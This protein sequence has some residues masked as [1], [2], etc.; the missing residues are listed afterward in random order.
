[1]ILQSAGRSLALLL[2]GAATIL[3]VSCTASHPPANQSSKTIRLAGDAWFLK[4]LVST[5]RIASFEQKTGVHVEVLEK[6]D[7]TILSDLDRGATATDPGY[8]L[9]VMRHRFMGTLVAKKQIQPIDSL[10]A[11]ASVHDI[12][13]YP[14]Q[15]LFPQ[16]WRELSWYGD[17]VYGY[18]Y[19]GLTAF[20]CYRKDMLED[21]DNQRKFKARYHRSL[22]VPAH[23]KEYM[24]VAEFFTR[25]G[26]HFYGTYISGKR[27][28]ALWYEWLNL[29]YSFG[30]DVLDTQHGW[31]YG[32]IVVNSPQ[33][34]AA[35]KQY[36]KW[37]AN[38]PPDT[39][40]YG[41]NEAQAAL[42]Q[43]HAFMGLLWS[44]QAY[45][46][47]DHATSGVAG[48]IGYSLIPSNRSQR[49]SQLE[50]LSYFIPT[51]ARHP[52]EAYRFMEWAM[53]ESVQV[54]QTLKGSSS[55]RDSTYE[56]AAVQQQ[57]YTSAFLASVPIAK[58]KSTLP[59]ASRMTEAEEQRLS[60]IVTGKE[61]P[62][63]GLDK[64]ALDL[65]QILGSKSRLR[66]PVHR[67]S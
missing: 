56:K 41:W 67:A 15:Q 9:V 8:D 33:N 54:Q 53:S 4:S 52:K 47:E 1:M 61:S 24:Q 34:V 21:A 36:V 13:F 39:L 58:P 38:S 50:G 44:D 7:R 25:P 35:T 11:D 29:V 3:Q 59:E 32:D 14:A 49:A 16:W 63:S 6:N 51:G 2:L 60:D 31:E 19:T 46:L 48:K 62:Q 57:P 64:L 40:N 18:P 43:G 5:G 10:L 55:L 66:Y 27:G 65:Q 17:K 12:D 22:T 23:W 26:Q 45:L 30:G 42:Q 20:L 37:I 28:P